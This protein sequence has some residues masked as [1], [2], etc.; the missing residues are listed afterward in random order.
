MLSPSATA[1]SSTVP[2]IGLVTAPEAP[3]ASPFARSACRRRPRGLRGA[4]ADLM[5][6]AVDLDLDDLVTPRGPPCSVRPR[7]YSRCPMRKLLVQLLRPLCQLLG[8]DE[9]A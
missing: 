2:C 5:T 7:R 6:A 1:T 4:D 9:A 8:L 3:L